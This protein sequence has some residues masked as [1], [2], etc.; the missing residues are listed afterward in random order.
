MGK[1]M[2]RVKT[3]KVDGMVVSEFKR[4]EVYGF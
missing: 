1:E 2:V 4:G 3:E